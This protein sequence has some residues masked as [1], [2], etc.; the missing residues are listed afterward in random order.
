[1]ETRRKVCLFTIETPR[2]VQ[3]VALVACYQC[4]SNSARQRYSQQNDSMTRSTNSTHLPHN[5]YFTR[6]KTA[7]VKS[8]MPFARNKFSF[9][10]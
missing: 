8:F 7:Y 4:K 5:T 1:M 9:R 10:R 3:R 6:V 2:T